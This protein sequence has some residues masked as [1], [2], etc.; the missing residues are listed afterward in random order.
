MIIHP[1]YKPVFQVRLWV[2]IAKKFP[3]DH[4]SFHNQWH[5]LKGGE[6]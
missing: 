6:I 1:K 3:I 4:F 2:V 5:I